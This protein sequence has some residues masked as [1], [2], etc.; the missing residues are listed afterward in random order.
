[1]GRNGRFRKTSGFQEFSVWHAA[2]WV[3]GIVAGFPLTAFT[4][5]CAGPLGFSH[6]RGRNWSENHFFSAKS[7]R[8]HVQR[9]LAVHVW[10]NELWHCAG[11]S[12]QCDFR[13]LAGSARACGFF[14]GGRRSTNEQHRY[15]RGV[16]PTEKLFADFQTVYTA[17]RS[18]SKWVRK[19]TAI[20]ACAPAGEKQVFPSSLRGPV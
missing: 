17:C 2:T 7:A 16:F 8:T 12:R 4:T 19:K 9:V 5:N 20:R 6:S 3:A 11:S 13:G 1:M 10:E 18:P 15:G 14:E